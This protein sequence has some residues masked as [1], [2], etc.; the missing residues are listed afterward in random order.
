MVSQKTEIIKKFKIGKWLELTASY[1][2]GSSKSYDIMNQK[3]LL[4][5]FVT[6]HE[7]M[8]GQYKQQ[9]ERAQISASGQGVV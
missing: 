8:K 7:S 1:N 9:T 4:W 6:T 2:V 5:S 3:D